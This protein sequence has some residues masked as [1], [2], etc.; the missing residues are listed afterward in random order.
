LLG[1]AQRPHE[2]GEQ[3]IRKG[4]RYCRKLQ[5]QKDVGIAENLIRRIHHTQNRRAQQTGGKGYQ[6]RNNSRKPQRI[7][8]I[9]PHQRKVFSTESLRH[10]DGESGTSSIAEAHNEKHYRRGSPHGGKGINT[11]KPP[12]H[13]RIYY[14]IHLLQDIAADQRHRKLQ[15][16]ACRRTYCHIIYT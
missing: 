1:I 10:R 7:T 8:H 15:Y 12:H 3:I 11:N 5:Y 4:K 2:A 16:V 6:Q 9:L 14:Q 13:R